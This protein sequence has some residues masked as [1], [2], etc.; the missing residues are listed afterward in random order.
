MIQSHRYLPPAAVNCNW[1]STKLCE[2]WLKVR[3][4]TQ[5]LCGGSYFGTAAL[6]TSEFPKLVKDRPIHTQHATTWNVTTRHEVS[7]TKGYW[8]TSPGFSS[9]WR[10]GKSSSCTHHL[11]V[12]IIAEWRILGSSE[13]AACITSINAGKPDPRLGRKMS[14]ST[15]ILTSSHATSLSTCTWVGD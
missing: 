11:T 12:S 2:I 5:L 14:G 9:S 8:K 4:C 7:L 13:I 1:R 3:K 6:A 10:Y 15:W